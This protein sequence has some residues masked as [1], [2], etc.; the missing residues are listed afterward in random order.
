MAG[1]FGQANVSRNHGLEDLRTEKAAKIGRNLAGKRGALVVHRQDDAFDFE[2]RIQIAA[3]THEGVEK[4]GNA[5]ESQVFALDGD[6]DGVA[7][8][9]RIQR[10]EIE[11][12]RA[13]ENQEIILG[14]QRLD[15][16][17]ELKFAIFE[18]HHLD[19]GARQVF[20]GGKQFEVFERGFLDNRGGGFREQDDVIEGVAGGISGKAEAGRGIGLG[21]AIEQEGF[22]AF[23]GEG[24]GQIDCGGCFANPAFLVGDSDDSAQGQPPLL[25]WENLADGEWAGN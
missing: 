13:I 18:F 4:L 11:R 22:Q 24:S 7:C 25:F 20:I 16:L 6:E 19:R 2:F 14:F 23:G 17:L 5:F 8:G 9:E 10:E 15:G 21:I 3:N 12:G 1:R